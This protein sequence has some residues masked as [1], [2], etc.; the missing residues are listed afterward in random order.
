MGLKPCGS[1]VGDSV[2]LDLLPVPEIIFQI[3]RRK[4]RP[5]FRKKPAIFPKKL[6]VST[7]KRAI[8]A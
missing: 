1:I 5:S 2:I 4:N 8:F 6:A 3:L 7:G